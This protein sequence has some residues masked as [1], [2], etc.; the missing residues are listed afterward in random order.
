[1]RLPLIF[2]ASVLCAVALLS[3]A[4]SHAR[5]DKD[6]YRTFRIVAFGDNFTSGYGIDQKDA[7]PIVLRTR[8]NKE[9]TRERIEVINAGVSG[10]TS[11]TAVA[12][13]A[14]ILAEKP[15][16]VILAFGRTDAVKHLDP[17][18]T[19]KALDQMLSTLTYNNI[20]V[21][22][23]GFTAPDDASIE[24]AVRYNTNFPALAKRY[25]VVYYRDMLKGVADQPYMLQFDGIHPNEEGQ[26]Q[27]ANNLFVPLDGMLRK[28]RQRLF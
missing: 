26:V 5:P 27:I 17:N 14:S 20:Y 19:Y 3:P 13:L 22:M 24:Y 11:A 1:M 15:D 12:R 21:V 10:D 25:N 18:I 6:H 8:L 7:W 2:L 9:F 23:A 16:I 4:P 28:L